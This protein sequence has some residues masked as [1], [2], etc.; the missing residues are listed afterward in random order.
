M[1]N[2]IKIN[3]VFIIS[4]LITANLF[5]EFSTVCARSKKK[6]VE[7][8]YTWDDAMWKT[9]RRYGMITMGLC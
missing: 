9:R 8:I 4:L 5:S 2:G 1:L 6:P 7:K 3:K